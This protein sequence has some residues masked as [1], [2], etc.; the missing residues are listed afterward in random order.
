MAK[1][2]ILIIMLMLYKRPII[3]NR[4]QWL[5]YLTHSGRILKEKSI[6]FADQAEKKTDV[7]R[8]RNLADTQVLQSTSRFKGGL[9]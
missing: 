9:S 6:T 2:R 7:C 3:I 4:I 1:T 5:I 8:V